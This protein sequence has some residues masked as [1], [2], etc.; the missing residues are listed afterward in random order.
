MDL[1]WKSALEQLKNSG[2]LPEGEAITPPESSAGKPGTSE[3]LHVVVERKGRHGKTATIIEGFTCD[4]STLQD[5]ARKL[6]QTIG[7]GG[8]ARGGEILLQGEWREKVIEIL[9]KEGH[10][11][12]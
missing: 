9:R 6:K 11:I 7:T 5:I 4:D 3:K 8:S 12:S 10:K 2:N 1:N